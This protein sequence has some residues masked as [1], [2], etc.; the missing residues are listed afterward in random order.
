MVSV[1]VS[2][3]GGR[4]GGG[5]GRDQAEFNRAPS[6]NQ[7]KLMSLTVD[8]ATITAGPFF[9]LFLPFTHTKK[10]K[11][12]PNFFLK[13]VKTQHTKNGGSISPHF[14]S[15]LDFFCLGFGAVFL[16]AREAS[17]D[18]ASVTPLP[19]AAILLR[20]FLLFIR[21]SLLRFFASFPP[22]LVSLFLLRP[23]G[24]LKE[25]WAKW[26]LIFPFFSLFFPS[27]FFLLS[28]FFLSSFSPLSCVLL[29]SGDSQGLWAMLGQS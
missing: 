25:K 21:L 12:F 27:S 8:P 15:F 22:P 9:V 17:S 13:Q 16:G 3:G 23:K 10:G 6:S 28:L 18:W 14:P 20:L 11:M 5:G 24:T 7:L 29:L 1:H 4:E 2:V 19:P 26:G